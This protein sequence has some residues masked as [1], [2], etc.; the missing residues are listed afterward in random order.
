M[1]ALSGGGPEAALLARAQL[2]LA[3]EPSYPIFAATFSLASQGSLNARATIDAPTGG[4]DFG[5]L[6]A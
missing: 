1:F 3:H 5:D 2:I 4:K 6:M